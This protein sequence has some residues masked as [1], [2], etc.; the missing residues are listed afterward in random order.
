MR[1]LAIGRRSRLSPVEESCLADGGFFLDINRE[2]KGYLAA[3]T[4]RYGEGSRLAD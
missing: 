2:K 4:L 3:S 1:R